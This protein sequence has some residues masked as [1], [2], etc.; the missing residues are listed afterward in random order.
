MKTHSAG[1][2]LYRFTAG[3]L[4]VLLVHPGGPFWAHKDA[5]AWTLPKG[6]CEI[7]ESML[8]AAQREF[9]EETGFTAT[10]PFI[11]LG[12]LR[13]PGGK[14]VHAWAVEQDIDAAAIASNHFSL[15][16]PRNSGVVRNYPE[17]DRG[18]WFS[19]AEARTKILPGQAAFLD[20][21]VEWLGEV[22]L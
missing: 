12:E 16:W 21:L 1:L 5:G 14:I 13:Q 4:Q 19:V 20:R 11:P 6:L 18:Q 15:E 22:S 8:E 9:K 10:G 3:R 2:L 17:I 7:D